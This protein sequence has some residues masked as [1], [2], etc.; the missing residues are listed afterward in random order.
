MAASG[1]ADLKVVTKRQPT[2]QEITDMLLAFT[3]GKHVKSNAVV[4]VKDG[5]TAAIGAGQM[6]RVDSARIAAIKARDAAKE[7]GWP[8]PMTKGSAAASEAFFPFPDGLLA[9]AEAG[10][11]G[12]HP[13]RRF[14][15]RS[16]SDRSGRLSRTRHGFHRY[17]S[18]PALTVRINPKKYSQ[19]GTK[20]ATGA[21]S[22]RSP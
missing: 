22:P 1:R 2:E 17:A 9:V 8:E 20:V 14:H 21:L 5:V 10:A 19:S 3:I 18:F 15:R 7:A 12:G 6:S 13:A 4:Y 11:H 16:E